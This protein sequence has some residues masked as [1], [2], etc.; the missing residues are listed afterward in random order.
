MTVMALSSQSRGSYITGWIQLDH[1]VQLADR[2]RGRHARFIE[3]LTG[4][5]PPRSR[6]RVRI[7]KASFDRGYCF[8]NISDGYRCFAQQIDIVRVDVRS[9]DEFRNVDSNNRAIKQKVFE[10]D[11]TV[12]GDQYVGRGEIRTG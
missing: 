11:R 4:H 6:Q 10:P 8:A 5:R 2:A 3:E 7:T 9:R 1:V 12:I